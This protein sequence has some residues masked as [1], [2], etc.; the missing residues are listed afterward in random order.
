MKR[1][2]A[3]PPRFMRGL[4]GMRG[5]PRM[6]TAWWIKRNEAEMLR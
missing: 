4:A 3:W 2:D 1:I 5:Y 6:E